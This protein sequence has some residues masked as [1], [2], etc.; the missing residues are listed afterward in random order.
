MDAEMTGPSHPAAVAY[1][2]E[3]DTAAREASPSRLADVSLPARASSYSG[4]D[5]GGRSQQ[6]AVSAEALVGSAQAQLVGNG[7][8]EGHT[9]QAADSGWNGQPAAAVNVDSFE[10]VQLCSLLYCHSWIT[11]SLQS[12]HVGLTK[13]G[14]LKRTLDLSEP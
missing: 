4:A 11:Q 6:Q 5:S 10:Q 13:P 1:P 14:S 7:P 3:P 8:W 2:P 9:P 12:P